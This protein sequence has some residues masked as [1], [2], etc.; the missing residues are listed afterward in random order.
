M[1]NLLFGIDIAAI[2]AKEVGPGLLPATITEFVPGPAPARVTDAPTMTPVAHSCRGMWE[3]YSP[4][5]VRDSALIQVGD[6]KAL[7][8]GDT[9]PRG[10]IPAAGMVVTIEGKALVVIRIESRDPAAATYVLQCR[11]KAGLNGV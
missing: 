3:D 8:L 9:L 4:D 1:G 7:L 6:R 10:F 2:V 5:M 11:D